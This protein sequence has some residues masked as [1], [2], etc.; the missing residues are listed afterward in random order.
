MERV[1]RVMKYILWLIF[2]FFFEVSWK[3][4]RKMRSG[5]KREEGRGKEREIEKL[6]SRERKRC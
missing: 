4:N 3:K 6:R 2:Y 5:R 1:E